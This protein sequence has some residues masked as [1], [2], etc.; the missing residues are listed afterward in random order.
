MHTVT[1]ESP[2][3]N[4]QQNMNNLLTLNKTSGCAIKKLETYLKWKLTMEA[5]MAV[6]YDG[7]I[8]KK[9]CKYYL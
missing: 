9:W 3:I 8:L 1:T 7:M 4:S 5:T 2:S 6:K